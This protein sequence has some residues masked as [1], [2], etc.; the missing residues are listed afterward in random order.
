MKIKVVLLTK[1]AV[2]VE[3]N[4]PDA[5]E[6]NPEVKKEIRGGRSRRF[7]SRS[8]SRQREVKTLEGPALRCDQQEQTKT[9]EGQH[10]SPITLEHLQHD[11]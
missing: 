11:E 10:L 7:R 9:Q 4:G 6:E 5:E 2:D 1:V 3:E 8:W